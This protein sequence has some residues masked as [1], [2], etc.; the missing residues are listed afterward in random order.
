MRSAS[1]RVAVEMV[2]TL[3]DCARSNPFA[4]RTTARAWSHGTSTKR[5]VTRPV[6]SSVATMFNPLT[7]ARMRKISRISASLKCSEIF[8]PLY[9]GWDE[10]SA[11]APSSSRRDASEGA[12]S[13]TNGRDSGVG[14][15]GSSFAS[16]EI[17]GVWANC[18]RSAFSAMKRIWVSVC[19]APAVLVFR[20]IRA[21]RIAALVSTET[22]G[23]S[24]SANSTTRRIRPAEL[25][26][27]TAA[28]WG[29]SALYVA[30]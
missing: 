16:E 8:C 17:A 15:A 1:R 30:T 11:G 14:K 26:T 27:R 23:I 21:V 9:C 2:T 12:V 3:P 10:T 5:S 18:V 29:S 25:L 28:I 6:T 7:S 20:P 19:F 4:C 22:G 24:S 13:G